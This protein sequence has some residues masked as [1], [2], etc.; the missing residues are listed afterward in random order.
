MNINKIF[1]YFILNRTTKKV[2]MF[3]VGLIGNYGVS[4]PIVKDGKVLFFLLNNHILA[5]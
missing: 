3:P 4:T 1:F 5:Y 2:S